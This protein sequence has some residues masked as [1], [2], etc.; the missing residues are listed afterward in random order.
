MSALIEAAIA[1]AGAAGAPALESYPI[2]T[3]VPGHT[4]NLFPGVASAFAR[5]GFQVV[6][7]RKPDRPIMR[8]DLANVDPD[9]V[10]GGTQEP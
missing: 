8:H 9:T 10:S 2:D 1:A 3:T 7:R 6:A 4:G 5:H